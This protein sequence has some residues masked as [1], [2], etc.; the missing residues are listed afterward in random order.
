MKK[1]LLSILLGT[2]VLS[3]SNV[4]AF[5]AGDYVCDWYDY[6][7][8]SKWCGVVLQTL[9]RDRIK[10][11]VT[12]VNCNSGGFLG[13]CTHFNPVDCTGYKTLTNGTSGDIIIIGNYC[14]E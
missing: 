2:F 11:K 13:I 14:V 8:D 5:S 7:K 9:G 12:E 6:D 1:L 3:A 10:V 4:Y